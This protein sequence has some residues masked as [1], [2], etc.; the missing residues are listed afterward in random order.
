MI[1][2]STPSY[3][4]LEWEK[5]ADVQFSEIESYKLNINNETIAVLPANETKFVVNDGILGKRYIFQLEVGRNFRKF[6]FIDFLKMSKKNGKAIASIPVSV[7]WP[8]VSEPEHHVFVNGSNQLII[9]WGD[10]KSINDGNI[11]SYTVCFFI[12]KE[13]LIIFLF[14]SF[15][16]MIL[17]VNF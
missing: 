14:Y 7:V 13:K 10:S 12:Q 9:C 4:Y 5:A 6:K 11:E 3:V 2:K 16:C 15:L 8:G 1:R 17:N